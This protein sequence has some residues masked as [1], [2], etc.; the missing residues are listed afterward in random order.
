MGVSTSIIMFA[1]GAVLRFTTTGHTA[2]F[3]DHTIGV[4]LMV[5]SAI[6]FLV[7][8]IFWASWGGFG[9]FRRNGP[10]F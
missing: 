9:D 10:H 4:V 8:L 2:P 7:S 5:V 1:M 3:T 6:V